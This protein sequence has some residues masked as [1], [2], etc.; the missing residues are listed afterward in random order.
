MW[1][2][3][4]KN[5]IKSI[6]SCLQL[7]SWVCQF[8][9]VCVCMCSLICYFSP[10]YHHA[11]YSARENRF[12][13]DH[14]WSQQPSVCSLIFQLTIDRVTG[15]GTNG[16]VQQSPINWLSTRWKYKTG[17]CCFLAPDSLSLCLDRLEN[18]LWARW[19]YDHWFSRGNSQIVAKCSPPS[20]N[21]CSHYSLYK[22]AG[23]IRLSSVLWLLE[24][25][26]DFHSRS[27]ANHDTNLLF[28]LNLLQMSL[29]METTRGPFASLATL[30]FNPQLQFM[31]I[32]S[33]TARVNT[34]W[35]WC[36]SVEESAA[37]LT[38]FPP[39]LEVNLPSYHFPPVS[40]ARWLPLEHE[41]TLSRLLFPSVASEKKSTLIPKKW[42]RQ[43]CLP[44]CLA[45]AH[46][47]CKKKYPIL[48]EHNVVRAQSFDI[49]TGNLIHVLLQ[50]RKRHFTGP[51]PLCTKE[52]KG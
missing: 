23:P 32:C 26:P 30:S 28:H 1:A 34:P 41:S 9:A 7:P 40:Y 16:C 25:S 6:F 5:K 36:T 22:Q 17:S 43:K 14:N 29:C 42:N 47:S 19:G 11:T 37:P 24:Q 45:W 50:Q 12:E 39:V 15:L 38:L 49:S 48:P 13:W 27:P 3:K 31:Q 51:P 10:W 21:N 20:S 52:W 35:K 46:H 44:F 33:A 18:M 8:V 4:K 2:L